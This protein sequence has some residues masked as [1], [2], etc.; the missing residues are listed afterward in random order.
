MRKSANCP[1]PHIEGIDLAPEM[2]AHARRAAGP[3][4]NVRF[5]CADVVDLAY[6]DNSFDLVIATMSLHHWADA[7][8]GMR[9]VRRVLRESG[10][11]WIY[12]FRFFLR[13][14][15]AATRTAF[16]RHTLRRDGVSALAGRL[17]VS[18]A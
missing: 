1:D 10:Q 2:I 16:P 7:A 11:V 12:E 4:S 15:E 13:R 9:Q 5:A 6:P 18:P 8:A 17:T 14:A 3:D